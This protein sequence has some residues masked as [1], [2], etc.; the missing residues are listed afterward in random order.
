MKYAQALTAVCIILAAL[1]AAAA[2][3]L[4]PGAVDTPTAARLAW[5]VGLTVAA[6]VFAV[7]ARRLRS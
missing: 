6:L 2:V 3:L 1:S 7:T 5:I 4:V